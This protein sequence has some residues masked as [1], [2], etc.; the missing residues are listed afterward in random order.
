MADAING[1]TKLETI[2]AA[3]FSI[4]YKSSHLVGDLKTQLDALYDEGL[5]EICEAWDWKFL[6]TT[7]VMAISDT[8]RSYDFAANSI[9]VDQI[10][11]I[12]ITTSGQSRKLVKKNYGYIKDIDIESTDAGTPNYYAEWGDSLIYFERALDQDLSASLIYKQLPAMVI[13]DDSYSVI[14]RKNQKIHRYYI[15]WKLA[16]D[17]GDQRAGLFERE[18]ESALQKGIINDQQELDSGDFYEMPGDPGGSYDHTFNDSLRD[19]Y[20]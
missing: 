8:D 7:A 16:S 13:A 10:E 4:G 12:F 17:K 5:L 6:H 19:W 9:Y 3:A 20:K 15:R 2:T 18:Y 14:P 1:Q 11:N